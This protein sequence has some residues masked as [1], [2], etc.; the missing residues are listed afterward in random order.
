MNAAS[1]PLPAKVPAGVPLRPDM[2]PTGSITKLPK[3]R[4]AI[5]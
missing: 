1:S 5:R 4:P 2:T 3:P